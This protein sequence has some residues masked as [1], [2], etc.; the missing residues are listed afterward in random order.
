MSSI[1]GNGSTTPSHVTNI[2]RGVNGFFP[3]KNAEKVKF[4]SLLTERFPQI[5]HPNVVFHHTL[6]VVIFS[7]RKFDIF[8]LKAVLPKIVSWEGK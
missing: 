8:D 5:D 3:N 1:L 6:S 7:L 2:V 4:P